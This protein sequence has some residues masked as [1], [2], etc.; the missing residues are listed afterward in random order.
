MLV[1]TCM[2]TPIKLAFIEDDYKYINAWLTVE[3]FIDIS[4]LFDIVLNFFTAFYIDEFIIEDDRAV[5]IFFKSFQTIAKNY[6]TSWFA[7][8]VI[9]IIPFEAIIK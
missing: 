1:T 8:D 4:F 2:L 6:L 3:Y 5:N 7:I 9:A